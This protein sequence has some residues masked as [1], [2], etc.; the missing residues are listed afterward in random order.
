MNYEWGVLRL[1]PNAKPIIDFVLR[2]D[3]DGRGVYIDK[4]DE[5]KL[6]P[7]PTIEAIE[8]AAIE[9][10]NERAIPDQA[11]M[12]YEKLKSGEKMTL[13]EVV[14]ILRKKL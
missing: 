1:H 6:G 14:E 4:W 12:L 9:A 13:D 2:N 8:T 5:E 3:L 10:E 11:T 7:K